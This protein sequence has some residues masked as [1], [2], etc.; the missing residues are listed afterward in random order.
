MVHDDGGAPC[1]DGD[2]STLAIC[3]ASIRNAALP[4]DI[5]IGMVSSTLAKASDATDLVATQENSVVYI[6]T[7]ESRMTMNEYCD[8]YSDRSDAIYDF[9]SGKPVQKLNPFH[10]TKDEQ[11][12]DLRT[13]VLMLKDVKRCIGSTARERTFV[14]AELAKNVPRGQLTLY[15]GDTDYDAWMTIANETQA[16]KNPVHI[17]S[18]DKARQ[19]RVNA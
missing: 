10:T 5:I 9:S 13:G 1:H 3:K 15:P 4:G 11:K 12:S 14:P 18:S 2:V 16:V 6:T 17:G 8:L 19:R 7:V